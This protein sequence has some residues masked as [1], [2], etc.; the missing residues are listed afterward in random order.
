MHRQAQGGLPARRVRRIFKA[1][2]GLLQAEDNGAHPIA[3]PRRPVPG[4]DRRGSRGRGQAYFAAYSPVGACLCD[5]HR[6]QAAILRGAQP[7]H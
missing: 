5:V 7:R 2:L 6:G 3:H 4:A 1:A